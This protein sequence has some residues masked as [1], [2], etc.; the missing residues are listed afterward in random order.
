MDAPFRTGAPTPA[1]IR[2]AMGFRSS[3]GMC[4]PSRHPAEGYPQALIIALGNLAIRKIGKLVHELGTVFDLRMTG[5][6]PS[7]CKPILTFRFLAGDWV[8]LM[9]LR[10]SIPANG[11]QGVIEV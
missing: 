10:H 7:G 9:V 8:T 2:I 3:S 11:L 6:T 5:V 1:L 4:V